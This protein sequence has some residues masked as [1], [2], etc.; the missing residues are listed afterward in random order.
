MIFP[1]FGLKLSAKN[2][3]KQR[4][5]QFDGVYPLLLTDVHDADTTKFI[6]IIDN[7]LKHRSITVESRVDFI[8]P[9][10]KGCYFSTQSIEYDNVQSFLSSS[11]HGKSYLFH[12]EDSLNASS[13]FLNEFK[14]PSR[15][16]GENFFEYFPR[17][18]VAGHAL[19]MGGKGYRSHLHCDPFQWTGMLIPCL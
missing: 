17:S 4:F 14:L 19:Y 12:D 1:M 15:L 3:S 10:K 13:T 2:I 18:T 5:A 16:F 9:K 7:I 8:R 6:G 11:N